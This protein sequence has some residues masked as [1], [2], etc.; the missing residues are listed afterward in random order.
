[1]SSTFKHLPLLAACFLGSCMVGPDFRTPA[2]DLPA[3]WE[4]NRP[5]HSSDKDLRSWW[6]IFGDPQLN[7]LVSTSLNNNPDMK[8]ALLRIRE[9]REKLR[10]SQASLLPSADASTGWSLSPDR[11]FRS[12]TSQNFSLG[13]STSWE[14][15][16]FGG[17]RR[18]IEASRASLMSTEA[19]AGAVRTALLADVATAYFDWITACEQLR[20]AREQLEIQRST[21][22]IAEKRYKTE[23]APRLDVEQAT[24]TVAS[25]ESRIPQLEAQVAS[26]KNQLA[27]L[28]G[29]YN[30]RVELTLPKASVFEK[31][32]VV[33]VGLPS[34]LLRR[35]PDVIAA[36]ADLH[37][38]VANVGVAVA[39]LYPRF[40]LTGSLPSELLRRRPDV[41]AAEAD[42]HA[43]VANVGVAVADLYPRFSLTGSLSSRGGDFG[44]LFREN[45]NAW[46]LGG[47]LLQTLFQGGALRAT[48]R[49]QKAV[50]EQAAETYRKTLITAV[51]EVEDALIAYGNYTSQMQ[52][53]HKENNANKEA[54]QLSRTLYINGETD[55]LNVITAQR[56]WLSSEESL[57]T[58]KQNIRKA[59]VQLARALGGG[60]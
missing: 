44:Q 51:S 22:T 3:T 11:G 35:R 53:L 18:S 52:Y 33:P 14:L 6:N 7:R 42:L 37:A 43:A 29:T 54:F 15:D 20:I 4:A 27:V 24:S 36:E 47:N 23:F 19:S 16:L 26:S 5:P 12:S 41:I 55:F 28:L 38:A 21:L 59:V 32:P 31:T 1:M 10:V 40:S 50:A 13:A 58:M 48:V 8:V 2:N 57:V 30:S 39:D 60:W 56:S 46:S 34:E 9:A 17:N 45:N 25:T 49:A